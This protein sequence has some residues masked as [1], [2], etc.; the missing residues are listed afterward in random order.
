MSLELL[1]DHVDGD[2]IYQYL[3]FLLSVYSPTAKAQILP[4]NFTTLN[5]FDDRDLGALIVRNS[6]S[7]ATFLVDVKAD[8]CPSIS[9]SFNGI[10]LG[11]PNATFTYNDPC[12]QGGSMSP[13]WR[14][15]LRIPVLTEGTSGPYSANL[16]N[17]AGTTTLPKA[18]ITV[19]GM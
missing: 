9:W 15:T 16:T 13:N 10:P 17:M 4:Y 7:D 19:P 3:L 6:G 18:Y 1:C 5:A 11:Q 8:P 12:T 2:K 14:F